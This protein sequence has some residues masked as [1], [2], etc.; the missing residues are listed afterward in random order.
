[1]KRTVV[2]LLIIAAACADG[3][4]STTAP[5]ATAPDTTAG[6]VIV[7]GIAAEELDGTWLFWHR[8]NGGDDALLGGQASIVDGCLYIDDTIVIW[9]AN[10]LARAEAVIQT[11]ASGETPQ[12]SVGG[13]G[14]SLDEDEDGR[15]IP[16][17]IL[18]RCPTRAVWYG[19]AG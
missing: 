11:V 9:H 12:V 5:D 8:P 6:V 13:S 2:V 14:L 15:A 1:M 4:S 10:D 18:E 7:D 17:V 3:G 19:N 16:Q